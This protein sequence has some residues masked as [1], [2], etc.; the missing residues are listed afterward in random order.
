MF[1]FENFSEQPKILLTTANGVPIYVFFRG[2]KLLIHLR[3]DIY[4]IR[5]P[6]FDPPPPP[7]GFKK[8]SQ[9]QLSIVCLEEEK[10]LHPKGFF[11]AGKME[12]ALTLIGYAMERGGGGGPFFFPPCIQGTRTLFLGGNKGCVGQF[13]DAYK[14]IIT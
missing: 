1:M 4:R 9:S 11:L 10:E 7:P 5:P 8:S 6:L 12:W 14:G 2:G 13:A 3:I